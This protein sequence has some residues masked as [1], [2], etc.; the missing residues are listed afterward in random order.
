VTVSAGCGLRII[1][2]RLG[3]TDNLPISLELLPS[4]SGTIIAH[5]ALIATTIRYW[6]SLKNRVRHW[7]DCSRL[8]TN[9][10]C[11]GNW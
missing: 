10:A 4:A 2:E 6:Y 5:S 3:L 1:T 11:P 7:M 9:R 8:R